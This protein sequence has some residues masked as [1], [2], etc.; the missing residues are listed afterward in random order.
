MNATMKHGETTETIRSIGICA[1]C[2]TV[3]RTEY[4]TRYNLGWLEVNVNGRWT[5][6]CRG[7]APR[8][9]CPNCECP[10]VPTRTIIATETK[11]ECG[12]RCQG[13]TGP[14]CDCHCKGAN[15]GGAA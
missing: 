15:H 12:D 9:T 8:P 1:E 10:A 2:R 4:A 11:T 5:D 6:T 13:A 7:Q 14:N 3:V